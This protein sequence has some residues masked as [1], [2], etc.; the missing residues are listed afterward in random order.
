MNTNY[1]VIILIGLFLGSIAMSVFL[2]SSTK[3]VDENRLSYHKLSKELHVIKQIDSFYGKKTQN[4]AKIF[5]IINKYNN[6]V[7]YKKEDKKSIEF[8]ISKINDKMLNKLNKEIINAG[9]K[10]TMLKIKRLDAHMS[11][12]SCKVVF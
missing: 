10:I 7:I 12:F 9:L 3:S 2:K 6:N 4:K 5:S 1:K 8:K 11:E